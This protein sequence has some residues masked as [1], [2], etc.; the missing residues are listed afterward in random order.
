MA[1]TSV[2]ASRPKQTGERFEP[3][4]MSGH[5]I[6]AEHLARY[7]WA[8][9]FA[10]GRRALDA[11]CGMGYGTRML[12][13]AGATEAVGID[14]DEAVVAEIRAGAVPGLR[15]DVGDLYELP[16][17][18]DQFDLVVCFEA[19]EHVE[20]RE[21]VL[22]ELRRVLSS[23]G[24]LV[25]S[26][27]NRDVYLPGNP[28]HVRE[29]APR[30]LEAELSKRFRSVALRR[31]HSWAASGVFDD[32]TFRV[33]G[34]EV[35]EGAELRKARG[36]EPGRETYT[37][38]LASDGE[39]PAGRASLCLTADVDIRAWAEG[40]DRVA[41][42]EDEAYEA[43]G[44]RIGAET[45]SLRREVGELRLQLSAGEA[46]IARY[47]GI[48]DELTDLHAVMKQ[49]ETVCSEYEAVI[50]STSWRV[51]RPLRW[52]FGLRRR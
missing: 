38:A 14:R 23:N 45:K 37:L 17:K 15:F 49:H 20:R 3:D 51:T 35:I 9:Q 10:A 36:A 50:N 52:L 8:A 7:A 32:E 31:Q 18:D 39:L 28:H 30:E 29:L 40:M 26:T 42:L 41:R 12:V 47:I 24:L 34:F 19:I 16:Y 13:E 2:G 5:L 48:E 4:L 22:D 27:P 1:G 25:V 33:S 21:A 43:A 11:A 46:E 6:E 44:A